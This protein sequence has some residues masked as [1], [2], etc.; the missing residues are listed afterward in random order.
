[1]RI[2]GTGFR[3]MYQIAVG[4]NG[5][6][7]AVVPPTGLGVPLPPYPQPSI[8]AWIIS[9]QQGMWGRLC[10]HCKSYFRTNHVYMNTTC[11]YCQ[12]TADSL[13]FITEVQRRYLEAYCIAVVN[14]QKRNQT[15]KIDLDAITDNKP[16]WVYSEERQQFHFQCVHCRTEVDILGDYGWC[17]ECGR[18]N[19]R[20]LF[21][22]GLGESEQR[23]EKAEKDL[24]EPSER[25]REWEMLNNDCF[26]RFEALGNHIHAALLLYPAT[27]KRKKHI[28]SISFQRIFDAA[29]YLDLWFGIEIFLGVAPVDQDFVKLMLNRR[30]IVVH[31]GGKVDQEYID[32]TG[33]TSVRLNERVRLRSREIRRL[34]PL[35][36]SM[37]LNLLDGYESIS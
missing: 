34:I 3:G 6:L 1:M 24:K 10:P 27:P 14:V 36:R 22:K 23:F 12:K 17:P 5:A 25:A 19:G 2:S 15:V 31:N 21:L 8:L 20:D 9:D 28:G 11:P 30:H 18:T 26:S 16:E 33:D 29:E 35:V 4:L 7:L 13:A 32:R 37:A